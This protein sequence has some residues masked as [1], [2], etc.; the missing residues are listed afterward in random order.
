MKL[1][2]IVPAALAA[3]LLAPGC[4]STPATLGGPLVQDRPLVIGPPAVVGVDGPAGVT[5]LDTPVQPWL[6]AAPIVRSTADIMAEAARTPAVQLDLN[7]PRFRKT[8]PDR[9]TLPQNPNALPTPR[10]P[11]VADRSPESRTAQTVAAPTV[12]VATL[13]DTGALPPDT[14]GDVGPTQYL[15]GVN[16]RIRTIDKTTGAADGV[17]NA[18]VDTFFSSVRA[19]AGTSDPRVRYDRR[20]SR[21]FVVIINV[22]IPN[23]NLVAVSNTA[24][25]GPSTSWSFFQWTNTRT[26]GGVGGAASCLGD[27]PTLGV[28]EDALYIGVNQF[29]GASVSSPLTFDSTSLYVLNKQAL[30]GGTLSVVAFDGALPSAGSAGIYTPQGVD[31]VDANTNEG[32]FIGVDNA[33][34]GRLVLRRV[35]NPSAAPSLSGDVPIDVPVTALPINV[36]H[37]DG[38]A[39]LDGLDDRLLQAVVRNGRLW[40]THQ[41]AVD[42]SGVAI[43]SGGR[44]GVRWYELASL[45]ATPS[46]AQSGTVFDN[47]ST[48]PVSYFMGAIMPN[49]QGH[50]AL[51][52]TQAGA[53]A[54]V[55][56]AFTGRLSSDP[57][58]AMDPPE[59][60]STNTAFSYNVQ[61]G[62][63]DQRWGDYSYTSVDPT[64]DMTLWTL[65][66]YVDATNS[67]AVRLTRLLA[68]APAVLAT[69]TPNTLAPGLTGATVTVTGTS[70]G[71][72]GF[73]DPGA[74]FARRLAASF[75]GTG[76]TVT[77]A[78]VNSP[79]SLTLTVDTIGAAIGSRTLAVANPDGQTSSLAS[80][81]VIGDGMNQP[82]AF[83][84]V[85]ANRTIFDGGAG[86]SSGPLAFTVTDPEGS[87]VTVT[88]TSSNAA[89]IPAANVVLAGTGANRTV[90]VSSIGVLG[91]ST[92]TLTASDGAL[93]ATTNFVVTVSASMPPGPPQNFA[94]TVARNAVAFAWQAPPSAAVEPVLGYLLEAGYASGHTVASLPLGAVLGTSL[95]A[96][97][98]VF[99]VR[100]RAQTSSGFGPPS[101][102]VLV[103]TGQAGPPLAPLALLATVQGTAVALQWSENPLGP[104]I[105]GYQVHAGTAAGL[106]DVGVAPLPAA[107]RTFAANAPPGTYYVRVVAVNL[108]G[109][110][111]ASNEAV[112]TPGP[113]VCTLPTAPAG[114]AA[115]SAPGTIG[116]R[117]SAAQSGAIP[118]GYVLQ[119]GSVSG[120]ANLGTLAFGATATAVA[121]PV[122]A[123]PYFLRLLAVNACGPSPASAEASTVVP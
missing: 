55:N 120:A 60:Y 86:G 5:T 30:A 83:G 110:S 8:R 65:Q 12:D 38:L 72:R 81:L 109:A 56:T 11:A 90:T 92:I 19:G 27:Y 9:S 79:T 29:C 44:D 78:V 84:T 25:I 97:D 77:N 88:A 43:L 24:A 37:L 103:V 53:A 80:A 58:G 23:R 63:A 15:V 68:P 102:E 6:G 115:F 32:Y 59:I 3:I 64:D 52:M 69:V 100:L 47:A 57:A 107:A 112:L 1:S 66:Q 62:G 111:V 49:G 14:Q 39:P 114:L 121:G 91:A 99:F 118:T 40:T 93:T 104:V 17:L 70:T 2:S 34:F 105:V 22:T 54:R 31:N 76:V 42:A 116:V 122:P 67:Y 73:F 113:G 108:A 48:N 85:P 61:T 98:G 13:A 7:R 51:G 10:P 89:V 71:G 94:A 35:A 18:D 33:S 46:V 106:T 20:T 28:D 95:I 4:S 75:N 119:A 36:P 74:G 87:L 45:T 101:N 96:P 123:G 16:G 82:P 26:Q 41:I 21:W 117:W 50:V